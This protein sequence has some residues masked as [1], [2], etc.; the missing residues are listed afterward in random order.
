[1]ADCDCRPDEAHP[2]PS[3]CRDVSLHSV[4]VDEDDG[5]ARRTVFPCEVSE[6]AQTTTWLTADESAFADLAS[7][8]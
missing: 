5:A 4:V 1:M 7:M 6:E 8:R 3:D 2:L